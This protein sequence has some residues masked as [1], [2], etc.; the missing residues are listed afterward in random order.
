MHTQYKVNEGGRRGDETCVKVYACV[1]VRA[2]VCVCVCVCLCQKYL[3][4]TSSTPN[5]RESSF[6]SSVSLTLTSF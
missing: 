4:R 2:F 1:C 6:S 3:M 5:R